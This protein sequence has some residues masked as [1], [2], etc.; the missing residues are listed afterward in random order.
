MRPALRTLP[1]ALLDDEC[2]LDVPCIDLHRFYGVP[3]DRFLP[4]N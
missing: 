4:L 2:W 1:A 3:I